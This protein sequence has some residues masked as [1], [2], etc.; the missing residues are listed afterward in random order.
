MSFSL[1]VV[2]LLSSSL[3]PLV[4]FV[5]LNGASSGALKLPSGNA[6]DAETGAYFAQMT[7]VVASQFKGS[8]VQMTL[9]LVV[10]YGAW[11]SFLLLTFAAAAGA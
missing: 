2:W 1:L 7:P 11:R 5:I 4:V 9:S 10:T 3:P 6:I 8:P